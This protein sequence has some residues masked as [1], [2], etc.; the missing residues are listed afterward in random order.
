MRISEQPGSWVTERLCRVGGAVRAFANGPVTL[1][2]LIA[3][4]AAY[5]EWDDDTISNLQLLVISPDLDDFTHEFVAEHVALL[6]ERNVTVHEVKVRSADRAQRHLDDGI[7]T[8]LDLGGWYVVAAE[9][10]LAVPAECFH[11]LYS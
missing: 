3:I 4:A 5:G 6:H 8:V 9:I 11:F 10:S 7:P 1:T 2:A